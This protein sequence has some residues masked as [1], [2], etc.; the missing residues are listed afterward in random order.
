[1]VIYL[2]VFIENIEN[3][4]ILERKKRIFYKIFIFKNYLINILS[5]KV[6]LV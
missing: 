1:M 2:L 4:K 5:F 3:I 6:F